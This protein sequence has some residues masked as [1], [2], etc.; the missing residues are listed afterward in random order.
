MATGHP[1]YDWP[2]AD[3]REWYQ[4]EF[5]DDYLWRKRNTAVG[6]DL[7]ILHAKLSEYLKTRNCE[8]LAIPDPFIFGRYCGNRHQAPLAGTIQTP[9]L[10][11][12]ENLKSRRALW[13][14]WTPPDVK[15]KGDDVLWEETAQESPTSPKNLSCFKVEHL[16]KSLEYLEGIFRMIYL[17]QSS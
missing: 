10:R 8:T 7:R 5:V 15:S 14:R 16:M 12:L 13:E 3:S 1:G 4:S 11:G 17:Q 9:C 2:L 6:H